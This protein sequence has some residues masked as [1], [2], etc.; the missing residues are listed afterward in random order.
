MLDEACKEHDMAYP[1]LTD[2]RRR[3]EAN[4]LLSDRVL[5]RFQ[6]LEPSFWGKA[7]GWANT[8][9]MKTKAS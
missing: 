8:I 5:K 7:V 3:R 2:T 4:T 1:R 9:P 6:A